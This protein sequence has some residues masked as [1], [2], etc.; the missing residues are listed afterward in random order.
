MA[1]AR[2]VVEVRTLNVAKDLRG[3][4]LLAVD[5][6]EKLG[7]VRDVIIQPVEG[8]V[9]GLVVRTLDNDELRLRINDATIGP[10]AVMTS[11]ESFEY[12]GDRAR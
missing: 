11:V 5:T 2:R 8:R 10:N 6:G 1:Q 4:S 3:M 7:E 9:T 12:A